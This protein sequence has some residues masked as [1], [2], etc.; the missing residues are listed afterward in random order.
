MIACS[1]SAERKTL[2][3]RWEVTSASL[4]V[5]AHSR[6]SEGA[7]KGRRAPSY[8]QLCLGL[9]L[10]TPTVR[11]GENAVT[12]LKHLAE[13]R[14]P[15]GTCAADRAYTGC[16]PENFQIPVRR[17]SAT[18]SLWITRRPTAVSRAAAKEP[19]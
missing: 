3:S 2:T 8:P 17:D 7:A 6:T 18:A 13:L 4:L 16:S 14:L 10:D 19:Y 15:T 5:A 1:Q 9:S 12:V 11:T